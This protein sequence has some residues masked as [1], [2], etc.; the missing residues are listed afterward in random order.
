MDA[1]A[2]MPRVLDV[3]AQVPHGAVR[4]YVMGERGAHNEASDR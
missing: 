2:A 1:V 4:A 3:G